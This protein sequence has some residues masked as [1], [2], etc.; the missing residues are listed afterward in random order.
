MGKIY[1][2]HEETARNISELMGNTHDD[3]IRLNTCDEA[4]LQAIATLLG[5]A[6]DTGGDVGTGTIFAR[7][8]KVIELAKNGQRKKF[9]SPISIKTYT[10]YTTITGKGTVFLGNKVLGSLVIDGVTVTCTSLNTSIIGY[11]IGHV[12]FYK[13]LKI[14]GTNALVVLY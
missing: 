11:S 7:L 5:T 8:N 13:S 4:T 10:S 14:S 2:G 1:L 3:L 9:R 6:G 12:N